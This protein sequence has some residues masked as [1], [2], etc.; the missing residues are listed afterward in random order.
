MKKEEVLKER[1]LHYSI[2]T[3]EINLILNKFR[4]EIE[5]L[6]EIL[7]TSDEEGSIV[8][9]ENLFHIQAILSYCLY[10]YDYPMDNFLKDFVYYF[11][12]QDEE[13][14]KYLIM[15]IKNHSLDFKS[16]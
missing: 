12:R 2:I 15:S 1:L 9:M 11:D 4:G 7:L 16:S 5:C 6:L 14:K 3:G 8:I 13:N 10:K